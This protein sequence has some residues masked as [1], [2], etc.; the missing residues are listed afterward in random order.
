LVTLLL[1]LAAQGSAHAQTSAS[2]EPQLVAIRVA[3]SKEASKRLFELR[4]RRLLAIELDG[5]A[6]VDQRAVGPLAGEL[7]RVW[8]DVPNARRAV[9]EVRRGGR[10]VAR[11][12][13]A[14]AT[15]DRSVAARV[16][17]IAAAE[18]V[19]VQAHIDTPATSTNAHSADGG[20]S[21][22]DAAFAFDATMATLLL[23]SS[24]PSALFGP[25]LGIEHRAAMSPNLSSAQT[26]YA[27]LLIGEEHTRR[28]RWL[29]AGAAL[30]LRMPLASS[31]RVRVAAK[32]GGVALQLPYAVAVNGTPT[33]GQEWT[34]RAG[35]LLGLEAALQ[36]YT[37]LSMTVEPGAILRSLSIEDAAGERSPL[38]GFAINFG[39]GL[40]TSPWATASTSTA[41]R[42]RDKTRPT[43]ALR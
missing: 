41:A 22:D 26:L 12:T 8:I 30:E 10:S 36:R 6:E 24:S 2:A 23:P 14:I 31:W 43:A 42:E 25:E 17:S 7:I 3:L 15:F 37:W 11:R 33:S 29:E 18:M 40:V 13:L 35:G 27:R 39:L 19:A 9:I 32:G 1:S 38:G 16:V 20:G 21:L 34:A 28:V 4:I 5:I